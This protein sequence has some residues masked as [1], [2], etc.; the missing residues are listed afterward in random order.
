MVDDKLRDDA[1]WEMAKVL[2]WKMEHRDTS[3]NDW[4][5]A[6]Q[7][8]K[9]IFFYCAAAALRRLDIIK[10]F[11]GWPDTNGD[12]IG[13]RDR[14]RPCVAPFLRFYECLG[15]VRRRHE[16]GLPSRGKVEFAS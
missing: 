14:R 11:Y 15:S 1:T 10:S 9:E 8:E 7:Q 5:E 3:G 4:D 12:D 13:K 6:P 2:H 16:A